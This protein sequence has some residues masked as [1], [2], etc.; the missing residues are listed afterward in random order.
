M[1]NENK[2]FEKENRVYKYYV[3]NM[4]EIDGAEEFIKSLFKLELISLDKS[5][6]Q[7]L[8]RLY[9]IVGFDKFFEIVA[10]FGS[11]P[12]KLPRADKVKRMLTIAMADWLVNGLGLDPKE[13]GRTFSEKL[14]MCNLKQKSIKNILKEL[15]MDIQHLAERANLEHAREVAESVKR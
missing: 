13:A 15:D 12:L 3:N 10:T 5:E 1:S 7:D 4:E 9:N 11:K 8:V 2:L 14:G 6:E